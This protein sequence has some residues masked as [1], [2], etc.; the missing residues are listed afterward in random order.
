MYMYNTEFRNICI[1]PIAINCTYI[2][3]DTPIEIIYTYI[4]YH[5]HI[6]WNYL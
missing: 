4:H 5:C 6:Y 3:T 1:Q 2:I